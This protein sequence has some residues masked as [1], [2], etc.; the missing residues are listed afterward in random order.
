MG[1]G[2][3]KR[4]R[5]GEREKWRRRNKYREREKDGDRGNHRDREEELITDAQGHRETQEDR[6][7]VTETLTH[8]ERHSQRLRAVVLYCGPHCFV[9]VIQ[10]LPRNISVSLCPFVIAQGKKLFSSPLPS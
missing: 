5:E 4:E 2:E 8:I 10:N 7:T 9:G 1:E 3:G 6:E